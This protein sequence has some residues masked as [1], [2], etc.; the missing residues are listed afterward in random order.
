MK[1]VS[2]DLL[3]ES[4]QVNIGRYRRGLMLRLHNAF[5]MAAHINLPV[6][7]RIIATIFIISTTGAAARLPG[8]K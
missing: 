4:L 8:K 7:F 5:S 2:S 6:N 1:A 3:S